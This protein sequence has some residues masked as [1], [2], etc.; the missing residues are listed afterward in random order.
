[1]QT[2]LTLFLAF[3]LAFTTSDSLSGLRN[4]IARRQDRLVSSG[5]VLQPGG[6]LPV[7][8]PS[9]EARQDAVSWDDMAYEHCDDGPFNEDLE[10]FSALAAGTDSQAFL[11]L[12]DD[13]YGR[14]VH[15]KTMAELAYIHFSADVTDGYWSDESVYSD[16]LCAG[17]EDSF[18]TACHEAL[19]GP[20]ASQLTDHVGQ[21][22]ADLFTG[23][24][25]L[26]AREEELLA[27]ETELSDEYYE[28]I[29]AVDQ[30]E[31]TYLGQSWTLDMIDGFQGTNLAYQDY[32]G[33]LEV[34]MGLQRAIAEQVG[35]IYQQL[36]RLRAEL[37]QLEGYDSY[38]D[39]AYEQT[40]LR[41]YTGEDAQALCDAVKPIARAYYRDLYYA[42]M[43]NETDSISPPLDADGLLQ[44]LRLG[45]E[46]LDR[47]WRTSGRA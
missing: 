25:P 41:D 15:A 4:S 29:N 26:T 18:L 34:F 38:T 30:V 31:Y 12:Y 44:A 42:D 9:A 46:K 13:L 5:D 1:M 7:L 11:A 6:D 23:Y 22:L 24:V 33:Y 28:R 36:I 47:R 45:A 19:E 3:L 2:I 10:Q 43:W 21:G 14:L 39:L 8:A 32:D 40:Y 20:C 27:R 16:N 17:M 37:A 35:P